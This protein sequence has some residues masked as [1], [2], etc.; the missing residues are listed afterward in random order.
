M[1]DIA[2][3]IQGLNED[4]NNSH[5]FVI[6]G[7]PSNQA[8]YERDVKYV[9]GTDANGSATFSET[10]PYT[11]SE[12]N[13][14]KSALQT[15][16]DNNQYQRD[17]K[18][19]YDKKTTGEQFDMMYHDEVDGTTTWKDWVAGIKSAHPKPSND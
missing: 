3:A 12:V 16:Y 18:V 8:E 7:E 15:E 14:K 17:R 10:Q 19:E 4:N 2:K 6:H 13:A 11:W 5:E 9:S 1:T